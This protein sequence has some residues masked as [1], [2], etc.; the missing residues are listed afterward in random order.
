MEKELRFDL[1]LL[2]GENLE[3][4]HYPEAILMSEN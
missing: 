3:L 4:T 2:T 1:I